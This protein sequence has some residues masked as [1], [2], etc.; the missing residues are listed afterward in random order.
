MS[1]K[2]GSRNLFW[3][4]S[5]AEWFKNGHMMLP[6]ALEGSNAMRTRD[7]A[8]TVQL[9][10][11]MKEPLRAAIEK[12]AEARGV[13]MNAGINDRLEQSF[14]EDARWRDLREALALALGA[15]VAALTL[16]IGLAVRD[17][18]RWASLRPKPG[19]LSNAFLFDQA[20]AAISTVIDTVR[21]DGDPTALP[22]GDFVP[23]EGQAVA[24][25]WRTLGPN[26]GA[27]VC[28]EIVDHSA[29]LGPWGSSIRDWLGPEAIERIR[30]KIAAFYGQV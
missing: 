9:K 4:I 28:K 26:I 25:Q 11:R 6:H 18:E 21:P 17:V 15:D 12:D 1:T 5:V 13:T 29:Q 24:E 27:Q 19:V 22:G 10:I 2:I 20:V 7:D 8:A 16:A 14:R 23:P 3:F 30:A